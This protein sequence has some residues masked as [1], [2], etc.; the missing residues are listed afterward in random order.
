M[1]PETPTT[2]AIDPRVN[3]NE[4][5]ASAVPTILA[6]ADAAEQFAAARRAAIR[7]LDVVRKSWQLA[8]L[9][10]DPPA[11]LTLPQLDRELHTLLAVAGA[12]GL[13]DLNLTETYVDAARPN[14][15]RRADADTGP[16]F[17]KRWTSKLR[18]LAVRV[19]VP[20]VTDAAVAADAVEGR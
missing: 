6:L 2:D 4:A 14:W 18:A 9:R 13:L 7:D 1:Q 15:T 3:L 16:R 12:A 11:V 20:P 5:I 8:H 17:A 10:H 19:P